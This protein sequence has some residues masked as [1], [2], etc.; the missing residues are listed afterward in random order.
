[1]TL[2]AV[3]AVLADFV[4]GFASPVPVAL[5]V[6]AGAAFGLAGRF[7]DGAWGI[8][9]AEPLAKRE[10]RAARAR[11]REAAQLQTL[12][13]GTPGSPDGSWLE[14]FAVPAGA[15]PRSGAARGGEES[16][17]ALFQAFGWVPPEAPSDAPRDAPRGAGA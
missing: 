16:A 8:G 10:L 2:G 7:A 5:L 11:G 4:R 1:M 13:E 12:S 14:A 9:L 17:E 6:L 3:L 15:A